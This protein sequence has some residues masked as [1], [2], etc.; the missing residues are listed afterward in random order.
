MDYQNYLHS[1]AWQALRAQAIERANGQ[2]ALCSKRSRLE[3][4]HRVYV[5][6]GQERLEHLVVLC[7]ECHRRH[8][9]TLASNYR[10]DG[11]QQL[12]LPFSAVIP[13]GPELN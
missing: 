13:V 1:D 11:G 9:G 3:V 4:H 12:Q 8:H 2:C 5:E 7:W 6:F 10:R